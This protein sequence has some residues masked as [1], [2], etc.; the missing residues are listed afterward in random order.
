MRGLVAHVSLRGTREPL[1]LIAAGGFLALGWP[2][3]GA[4]TGA[5]LALGL[6]DLNKTE[7]ARAVGNS[8][9]VGIVSAWC[10]CALWPTLFFEPRLLMLQLVAQL[11]ALLATATALEQIAH[12]AGRDSLRFWFS[13]VRWPLLT[14]LPLV[15]MAFPATGMVINFFA[16]SLFA[17]LA[18]RLRSA[19]F[20]HR[21][22]RLRRV[23]A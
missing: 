9:I 18:L 15:A 8:R 16:S 20:P 12:K 21:R 19:A 13:F 17:I 2:F 5:G 4:F 22:R 1:L 11:I 10:A 3:T 23:H 7:A 6:H 14:S